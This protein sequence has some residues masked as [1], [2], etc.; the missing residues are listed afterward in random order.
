MRLALGA[1]HRSVD[2]VVKSVKDLSG[3][4]FMEYAA[5]SYVTEQLADYVKLHD[6]V[7]MLEAVMDL[8]HGMITPRLIGPDLLTQVLR[9][10]AASLK[11]KSQTLCYDSAQEA[12]A[13]QSFHYGRHGHDLFIRLRLPYTSQA[14]TVYKTKIVPLPVAGKQQLVSELQGIPRY[15]TDGSMDSVGELDEPPTTSV[16]DTGVVKW[17]DRQRKSCLTQI[18]D[19]LPDR[20]TEYCDFSVSKRTIEQSFIRI[21]RGVTL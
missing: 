19:D 21:G 5:I 3:A 6:D 14:Y 16:V 12:Y 18:F 9:D 7:Q 1:E 11:S 20:V 15:I 2:A 13:I 4:S 8:V 10:V 17:H